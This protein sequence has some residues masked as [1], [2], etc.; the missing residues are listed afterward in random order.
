MREIKSAGST[1][2]P[3]AQSTALATSGI[4]Q[5]SRNPGYLGLAVIQV[6]LATLL[7]NAWIAVAALTAGAVTTIFV[8]KLEEDKLLTD[9]PQVAWALR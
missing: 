5:Y 2:D 7:D 3:F 6:G 9:I 4:Y 1:Y 8:I